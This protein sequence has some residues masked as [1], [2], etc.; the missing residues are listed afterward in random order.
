MRLVPIV[1][2]MVL[3]PSQSF[4]YDLGFVR[5]PDWMDPYATV[6]FGFSI[7]GML[8]TMLTKPRHVPF[9]ELYMHVREFPPAARVSYL[10]FCP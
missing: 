9:N 7:I 10:F 5:A 1:A 4:A 8:L 2:M 6:L 3:I